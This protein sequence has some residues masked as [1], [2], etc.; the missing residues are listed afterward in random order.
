VA[1]R[2]RDEV[3]RELAVAEAMATQARTEAE[4]F[5]KAPG[6]RGRAIRWLAR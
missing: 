1:E 4:R 6:L 2:E 3:R 5:Q